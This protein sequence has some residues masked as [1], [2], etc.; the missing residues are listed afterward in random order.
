MGSVSMIPTP[1]EPSE[2]HSLFLKRALRALAAIAIALSG[3]F[4][5]SVAMHPS[6]T[7][8]I[9]YWSS[10]KL[11]L[12]HLNPYSPAGVFSLERSGGFLAQSPLIMLNPP[13]ALFL[14]APLGLAG[15]Q[16]GFFL[17]TIAAI[18]CVL[19][20]VKLLNRSSTNNLLALAFAPVLA[21]LCSG[22]SS[23]F[24]LLGFCLFLYFQKRRPFLA[25]AALL[26]MA[27]KPHLFLVFWA[28]LLVEC[29]Q[30]RK[31]LV[32]VGFLSA[33]ALASIFP[34]CFDHQVWWHYIET[35]HSASLK[36][37]V[38]PTLSMVFRQIIDP[39]AVW[40]LFV[41]S[42]AA[43]VWG[44]W[45]YRRNRKV[46][47]WNTHGM[48]LMLVTILASPYGFFTDQIVLLPSIAFA[49]TFPKKRRYSGPLLLLINSIAFVPLVMPHASLTSLS[50]VW[51]PAAW[52]AWFLYATSGVKDRDLPARPGLPFR[53]KKLAS[54][55]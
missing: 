46:W 41:P 11:L 30:K 12:N 3:I 34:L 55:H 39:G 37:A 15:I 47:D 4:V 8:F 42:I 16:L 36:Q 14:I 33:L 40:L 1:H 27:L 10:A 31:F 32:P 7:D 28:V 5:L 22:Q 54:S 26:L 45:Y 38:F 43:I 49:L 53:I 18:G 6:C 44:L 17:W 9:E 51:T 48:L 50:L 35:V 24:L 21:C 23:P 13:W 25:G 19:V 52:L 20:F 29:I 2:R